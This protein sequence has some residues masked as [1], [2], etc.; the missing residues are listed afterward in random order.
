MR[1]KSTVFGKALKTRQQMVN[2]ERR[3]LIKL[4]K[5]DFLEEIASAAVT[6]D[7]NEIAS[8]L[9]NNHLVISMLY[10]GISGLDNRSIELLTSA[11]ICRLSLFMI[12]TITKELGFPEH[13]ITIL[14]GLE[15]AI[16][17]SDAS[18]NCI[19]EAELE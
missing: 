16:D 2:R 10:G 14:S 12:N 18:E 5:K 17:I 1:N 9:D 15:I 3:E 7:I 13:R 8:S 6:R 4:L 11:D 19:L